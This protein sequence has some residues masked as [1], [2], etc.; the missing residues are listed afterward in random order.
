M[1]EHR[2]QGI[3]PDAT[4]LLLPHSN[5]LRQEGILPP[6]SSLYTNITVRS[7]SASPMP[8]DCL[9]QFVSKLM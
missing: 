9:V 4:L 6:Q 8:V 2:E 7:F 3:Y 5:V 1:A